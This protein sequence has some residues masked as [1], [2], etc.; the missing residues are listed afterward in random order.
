MQSKYP[1]HFLILFLILAANSGTATAQTDSLCGNPFQNHYGPFDYR[2]ADAQNRAVVESVHFTPGV[3]ALIRPA[4]TTFTTMAGDVA[5]TLHVFPNHHRALL[6]MSRAAKKFGKDPAPGAR[7]TVNCYFERAVKF[8]PE[9]TVAR[10]LYAQYLAANARKDDAVRQLEI[11]TTFAKDNPFSQYNIGLLYFELGKFDK[12]L[13]RAH[14]AIALGNTRPELPDKLKA[15]N[16]WTELP[17]ATSGG[18]RAEPSRE[19]KKP[20]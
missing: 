19:G 3:E 8:R 12:A 10:A 2:T 7:F 11:A 4:T 15:I 9:D 16:K 17:G 13:E 18:I 20:E 6:T 1:W 14:A 5:Y